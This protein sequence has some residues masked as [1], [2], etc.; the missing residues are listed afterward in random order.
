MV[1]SEPVDASRRTRLANER[2]YLAWLRS[3][4]TA[5]AVA[6]GA[7][8]QKGDGAPALPRLS[9]RRRPCRSSAKGALGTP[10]ALRRLGLARARAQ[11]WAPRRLRS[12]PISWLRR[13]SDSSCPT[14]GEGEGLVIS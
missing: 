1:E 10:R 9:N 7:G 4:L 5:L 11:Y 8:K 3:S 6:V 13:R 14:T 2:T 12:Q